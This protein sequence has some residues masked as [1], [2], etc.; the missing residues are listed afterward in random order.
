MLVCGEKVKWSSAGRRE[1]WGLSLS[2]RSYW[3]GLDEGDDVWVTL[4]YRET[5]GI[6]SG[7]SHVNKD[8]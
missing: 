3:G 8:M 7:M 6:L 5:E 1:E 2:S 4:A